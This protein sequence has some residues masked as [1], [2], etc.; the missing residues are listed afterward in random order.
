M[1]YIR[2]NISSR[3]LAFVSSLVNRS[4]SFTRRQ[5]F[6]ILCKAKTVLKQKG[7][8]TKT[9]E[10]LLK[11]HPSDDSSTFG[12]L[13]SPAKKDDDT[14]AKN[15]TK[16]VG[17]YRSRLCDNKTKNSLWKAIA[18]K[19]DQKVLKKNTADPG[20][21]ED[22]LDCKPQFFDEIHKILVSKENVPQSNKEATKCCVDPSQ[23]PK[24]KDK[25]HVRQIR[26]FYNEDYNQTSAIV[27]PRR[28]N[29]KLA[30]QQTLQRL[31][32][33]FMTRKY[34]RTAEREE[35]KK[36]NAESETST[37]DM[38]MLFYLETFFF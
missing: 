28:R 22:D 6:Q 34:E 25:D 30:K 2:L 23:T 13:V 27:L 17:E 7:K 1:R 33:I 32:E 9:V 11:F 36:R 16:L 5:D 38:K 12:S 15:I 26:F 18:I 8:K 19:L 20:G 35:K 3:R 29:L 24:S 14:T 10:E 21:G 31:I 37:S 4:F